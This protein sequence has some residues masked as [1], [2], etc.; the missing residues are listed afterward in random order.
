MSTTSKKFMCLFRF[1]T[2][3]AP[4]SSSPEDMQAQYAAWKAW[5]A[6]FEKELIPGGPL[7]REG[8]IVRG[9]NATDGPFIEAKEVVAS[10]ATSRRARWRGRSRSSRIAH[11]HVPHHCVEIREMGY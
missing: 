1:P 8:A 4:K 11:G 6:K 5:M 7:K 2:E 9:G 3:A 10:Y